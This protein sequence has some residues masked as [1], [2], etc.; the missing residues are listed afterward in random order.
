MAEVE[1]AGA[2]AEP[3]APAQVLR[4]LVVVVVVVAGEEAGEARILVHL[5]EAVQIWG[6]RE[7]QEVEVEEVVE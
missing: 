1:V 5:P 6:P 7:E 3:L 2:G 4:Q